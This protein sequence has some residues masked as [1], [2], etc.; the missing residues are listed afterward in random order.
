MTELDRLGW[1][2]DGSYEFGGAEI[3]IRSTSER[4]GG[5]L[6]TALA[7]HW[8]AKET[9][10]VYSIVIADNSDPRKLAKEQ[11]HILYR[12]T[13]A[14][15]KTTDIRTL[16]RTFRADIEQYAFPDREDAIYADM[17]L[18]SKDG[19]NALVPSV[20]VPFMETLGRRRLA[21]AG[22]SLPADTY[23]A[24]Q[25]GAREVTPIHPAIELA[26]GSLES[27]TDAV[28]ANGEDPR[29]VVDRPVR[30]DVVASIGWGYDPII[31]VTKGVALHRMASHVA[32]L[33]LLGGD[34]IKGLVPM[35]E[36]SRTFELAS[37]KPN[38]MLPAVL[39]LFE[40]PS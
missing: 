2:V 37:L 30:V 22:L 5:W 28:P 26:E 7:G 33:E 6:D 38:E 17:S 21:R 29:P 35:I 14:I 9:Q 25:P 34:A 12:G 36:G 10:P 8:S 31:P 20:L 3:G 27:L 23:V 13:I 32:N 15:S 18:L 39:Q 24:V 40:S 11:Y 4:F 19:V 1:A 16:V